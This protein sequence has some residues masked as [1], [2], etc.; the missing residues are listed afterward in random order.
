MF[1]KYII[2]NDILNQI[3][4][5]KSNIFKSVKKICQILQNNIVVI[6]IHKYSTIRTAHKFEQWFFYA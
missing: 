3:I 1:D 4:Q 2:N 5:S 6:E